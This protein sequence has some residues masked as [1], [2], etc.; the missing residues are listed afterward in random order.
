MVTPA[1]PRFFWAPAM[2]HENFVTSIFLVIIFDDMSTIRG[3][4][5]VL[6]ISLNSTPKN[7]Y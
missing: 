5:P 6:G 2:I 7:I 1:G 4:P 3:T